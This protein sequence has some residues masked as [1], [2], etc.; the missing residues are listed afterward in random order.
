MSK[1]IYTEGKFYVNR[2]I[3]NYNDYGQSWTESSLEKISLSEAR[4]YDDFHSVFRLLKK[5]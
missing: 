2:P 3:H 4:L 1:L 5:N